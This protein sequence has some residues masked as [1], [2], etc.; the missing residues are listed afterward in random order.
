MEQIGKKSMMHDVFF[1]ILVLNF[2]YKSLN[3]VHTLPD[4]LICVGLLELQFYVYLLPSF[5]PRKVVTSLP[6]QRKKN[7]CNSTRFHSILILILS[8]ATLPVHTHI[9]TCT[10][11]IDCC[12]HG[13]GYIYI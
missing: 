1:F 6:I 8:T 3:K 12:I 5:L 7:T 11:N 13:K 9:H 4:H 2:S 10:M